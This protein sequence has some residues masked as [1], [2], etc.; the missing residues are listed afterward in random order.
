[1]FTKERDFVFTSQINFLCFGEL[2]PVKRATVLCKSTV[3]MKK[4]AYTQYK[5]SS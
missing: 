2:S 5:I 1:M 3:C 4:P